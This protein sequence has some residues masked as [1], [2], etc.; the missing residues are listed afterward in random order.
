MDTALLLVRFVL[1]AYLL[2]HGAQKAF[3]WFGGAG[4]SRTLHHL[5]AVAGHRPVWIWGTALVLGETIGGLLTILGW[6][7]PLGPLAI[8]ATM[9]GATA[10]HWPN[11]PWGQK[12]GYELPLTNLVVAI[13]L[14]LAGPGSYS[15][16]A[17]LGTQVPIELTRLATA[18]LFG[19]VVL[20]LVTRRGQQT[21][22]VSR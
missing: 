17:Y 3:G 16:D 14:A 21:V 15:L 10:Q 4:F 1:G 22:A 6:L 20:S 13:A 12:G 5:G 18:L 19:G 2:G 7:S 11:G 9:L 8:G